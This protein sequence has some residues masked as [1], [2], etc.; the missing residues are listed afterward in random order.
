MSTARNEAGVD[1]MAAL[2]DEE[3]YQ[4]H[5][6]PLPYNR[7]SGVFVDFFIGIAESLI[8]T[9]QPATV[10]DTGCAMGFLVE[11]FWDRGVKAWGIDISQY[12]VSKVRRDMQPY[13]RVGSLVDPISGTYDLVTCIEVL[14]HM[15]EAAAIQAIANLASTTDTILF[16]SS[17]TDFTE[18]THVNVHQSIWWLEQFQNVGFSPDLTFDASF[19][20]PQT[21]LLRRSSQ[22]RDSSVLRLFSEWL[23]LKAKI[24]AAEDTVR[25][26][27]DQRRSEGTATDTEPAV[28]TEIQE[29]KAEVNRLDER[30]Q[31]FEQLAERAEERALVF[32]KE[33][34]ASARERERVECAIANY[35]MRGDWDSNSQRSLVAKVEANSGKIHSLEPRIEDLTKLSATLHQEMEDVNTQV[36]EILSSRIW[37]ALVRSGGVLLKLAGRES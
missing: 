29:L 11:A 25:R 2:Y 15:P 24:A 35:T 8:R 31:S 9:L 22:P 19:V 6:G 10:L 12:A 21:M 18:P 16:S 32:L 1:K 34:E 33:I 5:L 13:C 7:E 30:V 14:E 27:A 26:L 36:K 17:P 28:R 23:R 4:S 20:A 37:R 3:Y